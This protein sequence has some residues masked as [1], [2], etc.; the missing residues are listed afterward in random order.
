LNQRLIALL[1]V[2]LTLFTHQK[3]PLQ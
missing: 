1:L 2:I 3:E